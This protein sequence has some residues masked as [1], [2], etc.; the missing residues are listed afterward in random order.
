MQ[1]TDMPYKVNNMW[2]N[3]EKRE[4]DELQIQRLTDDWPTEDLDTTEKKNNR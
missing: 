2:I 3:S 4:R 1:Y